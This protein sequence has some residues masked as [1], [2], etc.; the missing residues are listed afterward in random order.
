VGAQGTG[1]INFGAFPGGQTASGVVTG[2]PGILSTSLVEAWISPN[3]ATPD[4]SV[5]EQMMDWQRIQMVANNIVPG[6]GFTINAQLYPNNANLYGQ[7]SVAW[8]W[9]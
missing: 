8:V 7:Y 5:D 1:V 3:V 6:V 9:N 4:H 2:Q